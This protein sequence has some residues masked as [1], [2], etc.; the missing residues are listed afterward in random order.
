MHCSHMHDFL[1]ASIKRPE[2][3]DLRQVRFAYYTVN[4]YTNGHNGYEVIPST[5]DGDSNEVR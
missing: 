4:G 2:R 1:V 3:T 5:P